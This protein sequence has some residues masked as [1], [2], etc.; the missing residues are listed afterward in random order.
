MKNYRL[1]VPI[2]LVVFL[3]LSWFTLISG[4]VNKNSQYEDLLA[5]ARDFAGKKIAKYAVEN[6]RKALEIEDSPAIRQEVADLYKSLELHEERLIWCEQFI[7]DFPTSPEAYD[8]LLDAY[9]IDEKYERVFDILE[10]A[11]KR[12][13]DSEFIRETRNRLAY[14]TKLTYDTYEDVGVFSQNR[15]PVMN[16][17]GLWG[18]L[19]HTGRKL[20]RFEYSA[21]GPFTSSGFAPVVSKEGEAFFIDKDNDQV[22]EIDERFAR[23][24]P[25]VSDVFPAEAKD[26]KYYLVNR[27]NEILSEPYD[28]VSS[29]VQTPNASLKPS[30]QYVALSWLTGIVVVTIVILLFTLIMWIIARYFFRQRTLPFQ[31]TLAVG[32]VAWQYLVL[33]FALSLPSIF[34]GNSLF[35]IVLALMGIVFSAMIHARQVASLTHLD[36]NRKWQFIYLSIIMFAGVFSTIATLS[37]FISILR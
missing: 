37:R 2:A 31:H 20:S 30:L 4:A 36:D 7:T 25:I 33:F 13:V 16:D 26:G 11:E 9:I 18:Y 21:A 27:N 29:V 28:F 6:Y 12:S 15:C 35:G 14:L 5:T 24:G 17:K 3:I 23:L 19:S 10:V 22:T 8:S 32:K 34:S 1:I